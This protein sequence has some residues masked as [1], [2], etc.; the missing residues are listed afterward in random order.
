MNRIELSDRIAG[1]WR[2]SRYD[3]GKSQEYVARALG[4]SKKTIQ[5]WEAGEAS[6]NFRVALEWF[7]ALG[8]PMYPY[9]MSVIYPTEIEN[10]S[11]DSS[12]T[13]IRKALSV[14]ID[15]LDDLHVKELL[16][17]LYGDHGSSP[18]GL[19]DSMTAYLHL[20]LMMRIFIT[21]SIVNQYKLASEVGLTENESHVMPKIET[22]DRFLDTAK[23]FR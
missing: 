1:M 6:P 9:L 2:K 12:M 20:P 18:T 15:E 5:N 23:E 10:L 11:R 21:E 3:A 4:V 17:L 16:F 22:L 14:Y 19:L 13:D 8:V 7:D